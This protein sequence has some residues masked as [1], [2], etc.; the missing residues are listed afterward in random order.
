MNACHPQI[1]LVLETRGIVTVA[2]PI[3]DTDPV[4]IGAG[5]PHTIYTH[6]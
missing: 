5:S 2:F 6:K 4:L 3:G 1:I